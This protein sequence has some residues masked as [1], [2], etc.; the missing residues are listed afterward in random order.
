MMGIQYPREFS[1]SSR[2]SKQLKQQAATPQVPG[3]CAWRPGGRN[4][5][6]GEGISLLAL[7]RDATYFVLLVGSP[8]VLLV[9]NCLITS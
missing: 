6:G 2:P 7:G 1:S 8:L 5:G 3:S 9:V 4:L